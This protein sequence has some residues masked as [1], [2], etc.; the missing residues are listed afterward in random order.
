MK[1]YGI[2]VLLSICLS[3]TMQPM[4]LGAVLLDVTGNPLEKTEAMMALRAQ[5]V[6]NGV[7]LIGWEE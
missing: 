5:L 7:T 3:N 2:L 6:A 1:K 4:Q